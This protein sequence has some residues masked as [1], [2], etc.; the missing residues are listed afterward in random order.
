MIEFSMNEQVGKLVVKFPQVRQTLEK[1]GIDY[2]CGGKLSI[3]ETA[4]NLG[5]SADGVIKDLRR[6]I[7]DS[8][9][10]QQYRDWSTES[11]TELAGHIEET[12]HSFM[13]EQLPR[14]E[15]LL[16]KTL[17][18]HKEKH[19]QM[20]TALKETYTALKSEIELH[21]AKE[22]QI[23]FPFIRQI[24]NFQ[25]NQS[26]KP[27]LH[28]G[29]VENPIGQMEYEHDNAGKALDKMRQITLDYKLPEDTCNTFK[30]LYDGLKALE[31]DLHEHIHLE[32]NILF[33]RAIELEKSM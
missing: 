10:K 26:D 17:N 23:L 3:Q 14:L 19:G 33:P 9:D 4:E 16:D 6:A 21:L 28:C 30:A 8:T 13:K 29:S 20:L 27:E 12:H 25:Q 11:L 1:L 2:C 18:A 7:E 5:L 24:E 31:A 32:N 22:E 15:Q